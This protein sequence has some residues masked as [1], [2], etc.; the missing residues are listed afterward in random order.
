MKNLVAGVLLILISCNDG[1][2]RDKYSF[3]GKILER[4]SDGSTTP[5]A[6]AKIKM[7]FYKTLAPQAYSLK[8]TIDLITDSEGN[9]QLSMRFTE[10]SYDTYS[11][12]VDE[13]HFKNCGG[14]FEDVPIF[15]YQELHSVKNVNDIEAC[16]TSFIKVIADKLDDSSGNTLY[17]TRTKKSNP[18]IGGLSYIDS[19]AEVKFYYYSQNDILTL[20]FTVR[21]A[22]SEIVS[23]T[24][25]EVNLVPKTTTEIAV[26]F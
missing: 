25:Q 5:L 2:E 23:Q 18:S 21:N 7:T 4:A 15:E 8:E 22:A 16:A 11:I 17:M 10:D 12:N 9:Y 26:Q 3:S 24:S 19:D 6:G 1:I 20:K 14:Y 13:D